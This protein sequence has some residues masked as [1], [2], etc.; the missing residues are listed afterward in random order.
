MNAA[1]EQA[2]RDGLKAISRRD[3]DEFFRIHEAQAM[4]GSAICQYHLGWCYQQ[5]VGCTASPEQAVLWW[6]KAASQGDAHAQY[7]LGTCYERGEGVEPKPLAALAW[8][9]AANEQ[10]FSEA[11]SAMNRVAALLNASTPNT[12]LE[13]T[14]ER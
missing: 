10:G 14:R 9:S 2:V 12:S 11:K 8:Y 4:K 6:D 1:E 13:R 3:F 5:G 7:A